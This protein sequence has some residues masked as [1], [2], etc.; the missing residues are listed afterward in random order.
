MSEHNNMPVQDVTPAL[1]TPDELEKLILKLRWIG[2]ENEA[3]DLRALLARVA[4]GGGAALWPMD[5]D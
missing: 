3:A 5:T 4:T 2:L 1:P